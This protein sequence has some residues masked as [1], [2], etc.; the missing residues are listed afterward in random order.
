MFNYDALKLIINTPQVDT[1]Q[2]FLKLDS[3]SLNITICK[4]RKRYKY[5]AENYV[6]T[7]AYLVDATLFQS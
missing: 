3:V 4:H 5:N 1:A 2:R 6:L 7:Y